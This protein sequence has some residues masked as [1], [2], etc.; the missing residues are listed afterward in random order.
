MPIINLLTTLLF[1]LFVQSISAQFSVETN[2]A[3]ARYDIGENIQFEINSANSGIASYLIKYDNRATAIQSGSINVTAGVP[4]ILDYTHNEASHIQCVITLGNQ[5]VTAGAAIGCFDIEPLEPSPS[6]F[7]QFW[8]S[9]ISLLENVPM[10]PQLTQHSSTQYSTTYKINLANIDNR[11]VYGYIT[12]PNGTGPFPAVL[13]MPSFGNGA[14]IVQ[15]EE[16]FAEYSN[17]I[18]VAISIH[19]SAIDQADPN[20]YVPNDITDREENYY[21]Y[22]LLGGVRTIDYLFSRSD[23]N[24]TNVAVYGVSQGGGLSILMAGIDDRI[25]ICMNSIAILCENAGLKYNKASGF[26]YFISESRVAN[27]A[28]T[29]EAATINATKYYDAVHAAAQFEGQV[30][31]NV[32][33]LDEVTPPGTMLAAYNQFKGNNKVLLHSTK[34]DHQNPEE[35]WLDRFTMLRKFWPQATAN[36]P[37]PW[38][39]TT[40]GYFAEAGSNITI[41]ANAQ[42]SLSGIIEKDGIANSTWPVKWELVDGPGTVTFSNQNNRN[43]SASFTANG[44]YLLKFSAQDDVTLAAKDIF[45][46]VEDFVEVAVG[47]GGQPTLFDQTISFAPLEDK[48]NTDDPF[49][50][51]ATASSGL[52]TSF[53]ILS[54]PASISG[55]QITLT[56]Q[57]GTVVVEASQSGNAQY[58]SAPNV[59]R[60]FEVIEATTSGPCSSTEN[61]ALNKTVTQSGT[62]VGASADRA[63]DGNTDGNFWSTNS[64]TFTNWIPNSWWEINLGAIHQ[65]EEI[66]IWNRTDCCTSTLSNFHILISNSPFISTDLNTTINQQDVSNYYIDS[67][68]GLPTTELINTTGQFVRIQLAGTAALALAEVEII[69]CIGGDT[70]CTTIGQTCDD[71]NNCTINDVYDANCICNGTFQDDDNDGVCNANDSCPGGDDSID[72]NG[73]GIPDFC[74]TPSCIV[75]SI[76]NDGDVCTSY[77]VYDANCDCVGIYQ[78]SDND[79]ICDANDF[80]PPTPKERSVQICAT[81]LSPSG[82]QFEWEAENSAQQYYVHKKTLGA[83]SW[84]EPIATLPG[85]ATSYIDNNVNTGEAFEY[86]FF[87]EPFVIVKDTFCLP[88]N[89]NLAFN[90]SDVHGIGLCCSF[91]EGYY[92]IR[93]CGNLVGY[94]DDFGFDDF[95]SFTVCDNG[96]ACEEVIVNIK[97]SMWPDATSWSLT[98]IATG[99]IVASGGLTQP[100]AVRPEYGYIYAGSEVPALENRGTILLLVD[101]SYVPDLNAEIEQLKLDFILDGWKVEQRLIDSNDS[102]VNVKTQIQQVYNSVNDLTSLFLLG[103]IPVPY[104]GNIY[105]DTHT[106]HKG[107]WPADLYYGDMDGT[108]TDETVNITIAF[109]SENHNVPGDGKF[110]QSIIPSPIEL[111]VGRV[112]LSRMFLF[113]SSEIEL[114][115]NYLNKNHAFK[116]GQV[117]VVR[118]GLIDD[119]FNR[120]FAACAANG[121][122]NFSTMFGWENIDE[123]DYRTTLQNQSY[124]WSYGCGSGSNVDVSGVTSTANFANDN[125]KTVFT[126]LFGS[127]FGDWNHENNVLRAALAS[128]QTLTNVWAGNPDWFFHHMPMGYN[129]GF[130]TIQTQNADNGVYLPG[131]QNIHVALMGDPTLRMHPVLAPTS[132]NTTIS[133]NGVVNISWDAPN[134]ETITGYNIYRANSIDG[135]FVKI[136]NNLITLTTFKDLTPLDGNNVYI[137]KTIKLESSCSGTYYNPSLGVIDSIS[138]IDNCIVG[139]TCDDLDPCTTND[140]YD[141]NCDCIGTFEDSDNDGVCDFDDICP[142]GDDMLD[143]NGNGIPDFCDTSNCIAG[144]S[145][146]DSNSC[147]MNDVYDSNCDCIG[148]F[149]DSDNDGVCDFDDCA[150]TNAS[151]PAAPNSTCNDFDAA[152]TN[153][154]I[155]SDGCTCLGTPAT[156]CSIVVTNNEA[157]ITISG[158]IGNNI[159]AKVF[160][161]NWTEVWGCNPWYGAA[162]NST[163][164]ISGLTVGE[165]YYVSVQSSE[166]SF[167][168]VVVVSGN[169]CPDEDGDTVCDDNDICPGGDDLIDSDNDGTPDFCDDTNCIVGEN[170]DDLDPCTTN[171]IFDIDCNCTGTFQD[172]DND[173]V[174]DDN[175]ICPGGDD[176]VDSDNDGTPDFCDNT[177]CIV[178]NACDDLDDCTI[179]DVYD[180]DCN[181]SGTFQDTDNDTVCD[182]NDICPGGDDLIDS[183]NDGTPDF[184]DNT[185]CIIGD[186]CDDLDSNTSNDVYDT[187]CNCNGTTP[188]SYCSSNGNSTAY[189]YIEKIVAG[190]TENISGNNNGYADFTSVTFGATPGS[191]LTI[192][193]TPGFTGSIHFVYWR[194]WIDYNQDGDFLDSGEQVYQKKSKFTVQKNLAIPINALT[195]STRMRISLKA[196][197]YPEPCEVFAYG[198]VEDY[199]INITSSVAP[200]V[201]PE[202]TQINTA[203]DFDI[204]PNPVDDYVIVEL[205]QQLKT[206]TEVECFIYNAQGVLLKTK[207]I[208]DFIEEK[209]FTLDTSDLQNGYY[210]LVIQQNGFIKTAPFVKMNR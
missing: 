75:G 141:N 84:G 111:Q 74:D 5:S 18:T 95:Q 73:N 210:V 44:T 101:N 122:R 103:N 83:T 157:S 194:I 180:I 15:P 158:M 140:I 93:S 185:N 11:S 148:T 54:G 40:T 45:Y 61:V 22:G 145:C 147:T 47:T 50:I 167:F 53:S 29:H 127:Q 204:R 144:N 161:T 8:D 38:V 208:D 17:A 9:Q 100:I 109:F 115:R 80:D 192:R 162:C 143:N 65:I 6:D 68:A 196:D 79:G 64:V 181:C 28:A 197:G 175:D 130:S 3:T 128:G 33:Y 154:V 63:N 142:G 7:K 137:V 24:Q 160:E 190:N 55:N 46:T 135:E 129:I 176:L 121:F 136:N 72:T 105:P 66:N 207:S 78:D 39:A 165:T 23:F 25:D 150:P 118:R 27:G 172:T 51:A 26:P 94:G 4:A 91:G 1:C 43:T 37:W 108:W 49:N 146:D 59:I 96:N 178:G 149:Q 205:D 113:N 58:Y 188:I 88:S 183:D 20:A 134:N 177:N 90:I 112:D 114:T 169:N 87:K 116:T 200:F 156:G 124:L 184:C 107:A 203:F 36:P 171:D 155:Q 16:S 48:F 76:C 164:T 186:P 81:P 97:P 119:N 92:E 151:L 198:E 139:N 123:V 35:F 10:D 173:T 132:V 193:L 152:T 125:L 12:I 138:T 163:E 206:L 189:E 89:S 182:E 98:D 201:I 202:E 82:M 106:E 56:G 67:E 34:L 191:P 104:S 77:D 199:T 187:D 2:H 131:K 62:Q 117:D 70:S 13:I 110:D 166:C 159:N 85:T 168:E 209:R 69:G 133:T 174:C 179:N 60:S 126:M 31:M 32:S 71:L 170:C 19:N 120:Q 14:N 41:G 21:R 102:P 52:P 30:L 99:N 153:D 57:L 42:A 86:A 195:G